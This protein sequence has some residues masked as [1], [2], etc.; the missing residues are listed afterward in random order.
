[1]LLYYCNKMQNK[2]NIIS[3]Q[4]FVNQDTV[5]FFLVLYHSRCMESVFILFSISFTSVVCLNWNRQVSVARNKTLDTPQSTVYYVHTCSNWLYLI[6]EQ[7]IH[8]ISFPESSS[9]YSN[10]VSR[11]SSWVVILFYCLLVWA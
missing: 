5:V 8:V 9:F 10:F 2:V 6:K 1:M 4:N 3:S 7:K 11:P